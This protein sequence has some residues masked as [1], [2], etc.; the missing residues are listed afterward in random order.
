MPDLSPLSGEEQKPDFGAVR[1]VEDPTR[2]SASIPCCNN[3][4]GFQPLSGIRVSR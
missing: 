4:S 2:T 3:E 1:S